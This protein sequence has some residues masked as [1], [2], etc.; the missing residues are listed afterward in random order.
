M[1]RIST[2][3]FSALLL[4]MYSIPGQAQDNGKAKVKIKR[5]Q[6]GS[7]EEF[8]EEFDLEEGQDI[9]DILHQLDLLDEF[10]QLK[11]GQAFEISIRKLDG[12]QEIQNYDISF[13]PEGHE[14]KGFLGVKLKSADEEESASV[15]ALVSEVIG[16]TAAEESGLEAG[17]LIV[18][19][20]DEPIES[21]EE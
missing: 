5:S 9:E 13:F 15:G 14:F 18:Q 8:Y 17:D 12:D 16:G 2:Y 3:L 21:L 4:V 1:Q 19:V 10:G 6:D 11:D 20:D 7:T